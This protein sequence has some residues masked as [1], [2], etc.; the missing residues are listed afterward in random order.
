M[1]IWISGAEVYAPERLGILDLVMAGEK[2][3]YLGKPLHLEQCGLEVK[4][5]DGSGKRLVP[6]FIDAHVHVTGGG[7][8]GGFKTRTPELRL[9]DMVLA[10]VTT[11]V[12]CLG[13]DGVMR[14]ME[15]LIA[16][17]KGLKEQG[18]SAYCYTGSYQL[19]LRSLTGDVM[20]DICC[21]DEVIGVGEVAVNDHRSSCAGVDALRKVTSESRVAGILS[22]KAGIVNVHLGDGQD[23]FKDIYSVVE[24][25]Q[26]PLSQFVPTHCNRNPELFEK[27]IEYALKGGNVDFTT[28]T[29]PQF[30]EEGEVACGQALARMLAAGVPVERIT[31]TS[32][33]Q[34]SLPK[35][36]DAGAFVGLG[37]GKLSSLYAAVREAV[38]D[39][40]VPFE[41]AIK[42]ITSNPADRLKLKNKGRI[43]L[44]QDADVVLLD[45]ETLEIMDVFAL[46]KPMML[47][48]KQLVWDVF[49]EN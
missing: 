9:S 30:L 5:V 10:G 29:T 21:I 11:V 42:V 48:G 20:K 31:F 43:Q 37:V 40:R 22:G 17:V 12:G 15:N 26:I 3:V 18:V 47:G 35:F 2:I 34:G 45:D 8:E 27:G 7:G 13:T 19:P 36:D 14:S 1:L 28:S 38:V 46:G 41:L 32:D 33:G 6:G 49:E 25:S 39:V 16:K 4:H 24:T 23:F 44:D